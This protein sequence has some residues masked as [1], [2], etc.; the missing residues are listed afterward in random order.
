MT[1]PEGWTAINATI[2]TADYREPSGNERPF[3]HLT[4]S[5][6]VGEEFY[7]GECTDFATDS[8]MEYH[9][10]DTLEIEYSTAHPAKSRVPGSTTWWSK[11]RTPFAIGGAIGLAVIVIYILTHL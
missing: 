10:N 2:Y 9:P 1:V 11:A 7:S 6:R 5:Y 4:Y 8:E 3:W